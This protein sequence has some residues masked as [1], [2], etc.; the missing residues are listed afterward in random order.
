MATNPDD[1]PIE[2]PGD[3]PD[4]VVPP[5]EEPG[6]PDETSLATQPRRIVSMVGRFRHQ[7]GPDGYPTAVAAC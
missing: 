5:R 1:I 3:M 6:E 7:R 2:E 4:E